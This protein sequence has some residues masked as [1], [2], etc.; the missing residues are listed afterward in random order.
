[1]VRSIGAGPPRVAASVEAAIL[2]NRRPKQLETA[3]GSSKRSNRSFTHLWKLE[4]RRPKNP[5]ANLCLLRF[6]PGVHAVPLPEI[7]ILATPTGPLAQHVVMT[8]HMVPVMHVVVHL[9]RLH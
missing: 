6:I 1:M 8:A 9:Y 2:R 7:H 5:A 4:V 3:L